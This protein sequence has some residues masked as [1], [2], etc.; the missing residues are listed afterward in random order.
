[1]AK[2]SWSKA[3]NTLI[4]GDTHL[5]FTLPE[6][7]DFTCDLRRKYKCKRVVHIG[8]FI[9]NH[10]LNYHEHNPDGMSS[11]DEAKAVRDMSKDWIKAYPDLYICIGN[12][13]ALAFRKAVTH[14]ITASW[15]STF[16]QYLGTPESWQWALRWE[17]GGVQYTHGTGFSGRNAAITAASK[18]RQSTVIGHAHSYAGI[19]YSASEVN[20]LFG[21]NVGCGIDNTSYAF[22]YGKLH[23][24]KPVISAGIVI[25]D[26]FP[27]L[28]IADLGSRVALVKN[29]GIKRS[30]DPV[31]VMNMSRDELKEELRKMK[32]QYNPKANTPAL[33]SIYAR[34]YHLAQLRQEK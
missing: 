3:P 34:S 1:M 11:G 24:D 29:P 31:A 16:N 20:L 32:V 26:R 33:R 17:F 30:K 28:E 13:D 6:Y 19:Q 5:P 8:D 4:I 23:P 2:R 10:A 15:L 12:H 18:S 22:D 21:M 14:G 7:L 27:I 25:E 9:D